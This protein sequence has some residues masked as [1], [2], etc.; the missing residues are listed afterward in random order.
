M[1]CSQ[2]N[3]NQATTL[4]MTIVVVAVMVMVMVVVVDVCVAGVQTHG[5]CI[6]TTVR[7][8]MMLD[9]ILRCTVMQRLH[10]D[11]TPVLNLVEA[12]L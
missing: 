9:P 12:R 5:A 10:A 2:K 3:L 7:V 11:L 6:W 4:A 1:G 8:V